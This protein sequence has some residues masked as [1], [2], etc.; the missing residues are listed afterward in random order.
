MTILES[1][2]YGVVQGLTEFLP[3]SSTAHLRLLPEVLGKPDPGAAYTAVIQLGTV[4]AV[5]IYF[6]KDLLRALKGLFSNDRTTPDAKL[7]TAVVLATIPIVVIGFLCKDYIKGPLRSLNVIGIS[8]IVMGILMMVAEKTSKKARS[9]DDIKV[10]DGVIVGLWQVLPLI[11][12]MSRSGS[13]IT[14]A[15]FAGFDRETATR[16]SFL[17]S[18]PAITLAG[19]YAA[20]SD[21]KHLAGDMLIPTI[22]AAAVSFVVG[23]ACIKWLMGYVSKHGIGVFVAY[24]IVLGIVI[25]VLC[26]TGVVKPMSE[27]AQSHVQTQT[28]ASR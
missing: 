7:G 22:V 5:L 6:R 9:A 13:T 8:L 27:E 14:G 16:L 10:A 3:I 11:P 12:G 21:G 24:R 26:G 20:Y 28:P 18:V 2:L 4:L 15:L 25:L 17:M 19:L 1:V 23:Y